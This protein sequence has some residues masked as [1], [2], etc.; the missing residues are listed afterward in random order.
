MTKNSLGQ[1]FSHV[2]MCYKK[3]TQDL[4]K[5]YPAIVRIEYPTIH[6]HHYIIILAKD[7]QLSERVRKDIS[8]TCARYHP[9]VQNIRIRLDET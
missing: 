8:I 6:D 4:I 5:K 7:T 2:V 1:Y 9:F 3:C